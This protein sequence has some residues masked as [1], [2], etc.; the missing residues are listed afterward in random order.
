MS[1]NPA[2]GPDFVLTRV[3]D[4][5]RALLFKVW[6]EPEHLQQWFSPKGF[7]VL[8]GRMDLRP[9]GTYHYGMRMPNGQEMW[10]KWIF[11]EIV[12]PERL[13][14]INAFSD[15]EG[16]LGRHPLAP[17]WPQ[18]MLSTITFD[19]RDGKTTLTIRWSAYKASEIEQKTF[20]AGHESMK[21]GWGGT[22]EQLT[23]HLAAIPH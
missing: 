19:E 23:A 22:M 8:A 13:V 7:T 14:F 20:D 16:G 4:A 15:P 17:D 1:S 11:R 18:Q 12:A 9:G 6:T 2:A 21:M 5:P 3:F 10:G